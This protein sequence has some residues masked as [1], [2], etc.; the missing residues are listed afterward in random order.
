MRLFVKLIGLGVLLMGIYFLGQNIFFASHVYGYYFWRS[1]PA[2][3]SVLCLMG[4]ILSLVFFRRETGSLG[5]ILIGAGILLVFLSGGVFL[6]PTSLW[7]F[8]MAFLA[9]AVGYKLL[10]EGRVRF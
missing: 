10:S 9:I 3:G 7:Q 1:F 6:K 2:A 5:P 4:G 8:F